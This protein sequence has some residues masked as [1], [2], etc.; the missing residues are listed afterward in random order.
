MVQVFVYCGDDFV[1]SRKAFLNHLALLEN[2]KTEIVRI[3]GKEL[4]EEVLEMLST[5]VSLFGEKKVAAVEGLLSG[6]KSKEKEKII[7]RLSRW[8]GGEVILWESKDI[9]KNEQL[10]YPKNFVFKNFKLPPILFNFLDSLSPNKTDLNL[11]ALHEV[12]KEVDPNYLFLMLAR[13]VRLLLMAKDEK[14][15]PII[16]PWQKSKLIQQAKAFDIEKL[17]GFYRKLLEVDWEQ[18]TSSLPFPLAKMLELLI[19]DL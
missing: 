16:P 17:V 9:P 3:V 10:K 19:I 8:L 4:T 6:P 7:D 18:K 5:P 15:M 12:L 14:N 1:N 13:Q 11:K 2:Q